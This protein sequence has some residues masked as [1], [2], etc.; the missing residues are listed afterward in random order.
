MLGALW[1]E[2]TQEWAEDGSG[3]RAV[4]TK[5][6]VGLTRSRTHP[7]RTPMFRLMTLAALLA[8]PVAADERHPPKH[9]EDARRLVKHL[10]PADTK[11][12]HGP[13][14]IVWKGRVKAHCDCSGLVNHLLMHSYGHTE[15]D[16]KKWLGSTRPTA[17]RYYEAFAEGKTRRFR[18]IAHLE[19][20]RPGDV[21]AVKYLERQKGGDTGH[22]MIVDAA[23][24]EITPATP[25]KVEGA[26]R[27]WR[28]R[29]IDSAMSGHGKTDTRYE[30]GKKHTGVG[31]GLLR[32]YTNAAGEPIAYT[33]SPESRK[34]VYP[35]RTH[36]MVVGRYVKH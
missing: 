14:E 9:L 2:K 13:G 5:P 33:W 20:A 1:R 7:G 21:L 25:P 35:Q 6:D 19:N 15:E 34:T 36:P 12:G 18:R 31:R 30:E 11:Y 24:E 28:V 16:L 22:V 29:V 4:V 26:V 17:R 23:P 10:K 32:V 3:R 27:Q 8:A